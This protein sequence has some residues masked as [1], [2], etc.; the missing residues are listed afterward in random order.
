MEKQTVTVKN[1]DETC[2]VQK[3]VKEKYNR[4]RERAGVHKHGKKEKSEGAEGR[5]ICVCYHET[6]SVDTLV[7]GYAAVPR[8]STQ[9]TN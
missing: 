1:H 4:G 9:F 6:L 8:S 5:L 3:I 7:L 2:I